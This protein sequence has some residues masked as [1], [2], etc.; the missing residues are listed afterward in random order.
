MSDIGA[1]PA[2]PAARRHR[3]SVFGVQH[4]WQDLAHF[5][6]SNRLEDGVHAFPFPAAPEYHYE[7]YV[8]IRDG[9]PLLAHF[10]GAT[11]RKPD[12]VPKISGIPISGGLPATLVIPSD[13]ILDRD[14][15]IRLGWHIGSRG[16]DVHSLALE[17]IQHVGRISRAPRIVAWGGSGGGYAALRIARDIDGSVAFVWNPQTS[18]DAYSA[19]AVRAFRAVA[20]HERTTFAGM[21]STDLT[22][23]DAWEGYRGRAMCFQEESDWHVASHLL[24]IVRAVGSDLDADSLVASVT[25]SVDPRLSVAVSHWGDGHA[26]LPRP[27]IERV[28]GLLAS[29]P[30]IAP[31]A[32]LA[33]VRS[34]LLGA[35]ALQREVEPFTLP[36]VERLRPDDEL[37]ARS[38]GVAHAL[39]RLRELRRASSDDIPEAAR[40]IEA[41]LQDA[42]A[43]TSTSI[44]LGPSAAARAGLALLHLARQLGPVEESG[45][46]R[47][48][49]QEL[50]AAASRRAPARDAE[51]GPHLHASDEDRGLGSGCFV[52]GSCVSRDAFEFEDAPALAAYV[53]RSTLASAFAPVPQDVRGVDLAA[54][55]SA[56]Q[57]RMVETDLRKLLAEQLRAHEKGPV[58]LDFIDERLDVRMLGGSLV[59]QSP[60]LLRCMPPA[61]THQLVQS[62]SP[63]HVA[64]F[65]LG[66]QHLLSLVDPS[67]IIVNRVYWSEYDDQGERVVDAS[68]ADRNNELLDRFYRAAEEIGI[69]RFLT[70]DRSLLV[71]AAEHRW[72]RSPFHYVDGLYVSQLQQLARLEEDTQ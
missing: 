21:P 11:P 6:R 43:L 64:G 47:L 3:P 37:A 25:V 48:A 56:F 35:R 51:P 66:L 52:Y 45:R 10:H 58:L 65:R 63:A 23:A 61:P 15:A 22:R 2:H 7:F 46:L 9:A 60:E 49:S 32:V 72:G 18:I 55:P 38:D 59:T 41:A 54:N 36:T 50:L 14:A 29:D 68:T 19:P 40:L 16:L 20:D 28:L 8:R 69:E 42:D 34:M 39:L 31:D 70:Y 57:R 26:P 44:T 30:S 1:L 53:T 67:R 4:R 13:P 12:D 27:I 5:L 17:V 24:P 71:A 33:S 62:G